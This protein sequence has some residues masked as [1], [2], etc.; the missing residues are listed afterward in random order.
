MRPTGGRAD[1]NR[2]IVRCRRSPSTALASARQRFWKPS[3]IVITNGNSSPRRERTA[4]HPSASTVNR[5]TVLKVILGV[6]LFPMLAVLLLVLGSIVVEE[7]SNPPVVAIFGGLFSF[8][9]LAGVIAGRVLFHSPGKWVAKLE[10]INATPH[11]VV[12]LSLRYFRSRTLT[13]RL[14]TGFAILLAFLHLTLFF[15]G[16]ITTGELLLLALTTLVLPLGLFFRL[17]RAQWQLLRHLGR[18]KGQPAS[19]RLA[20]AREIAQAWS[21]DPVAGVIS[22]RL[23]AVR[24]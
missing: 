22:R 5:T 7:R 11:D 24:L 19:A 20:T 2:P 17:F 12:D 23:E 16:D 1:G 18:T 4:F 15:V 6:A 3:T 10:S 14:C 8:L 13:L 9:L 21:G